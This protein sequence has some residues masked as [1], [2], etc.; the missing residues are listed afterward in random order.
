[1]V[2][3]QPPSAG[4]FQLDLFP[5]IQITDSADVANIT[6]K[7]EDNGNVAF[8][9]NGVTSDKPNLRGNYFIYTFDTSSPRAVRMLKCAARFTHHLSRASP[10]NS[11]LAQALRVEFQLVKENKPSEQNI[12]QNNYA[13]IELK[14]GETLGPYCLVIHNTTEYDLWPFVITFDAGGLTVGEF[15]MLSIYHYGE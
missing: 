4:A 6:L 5:S 3:G 9:W 10:T 13:T 7:F 14:D 11:S 12:L 15:R 1:M 8:Y 2:D